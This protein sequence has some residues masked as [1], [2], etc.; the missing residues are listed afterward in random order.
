[1]IAITANQ[2][3]LQR[4]E[5]VLTE[6]RGSVGA[7]LPGAVVGDVTQNYRAGVRDLRGIA[8]FV[9]CIGYEIGGI[10][11]IRM[12]FSRGAAFAFAMTGLPAARRRGF[13][14]TSSQ[15]RLG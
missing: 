2:I 14:A 7:D 8:G 12:L 3:G 6:R 10:R 1:M 11:A 5:A 15:C 9:G 4:I 13:R